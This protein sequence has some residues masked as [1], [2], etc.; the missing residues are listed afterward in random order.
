M[1][2]FEKSHN[3]QKSSVSF[4]FVLLDVI[5]VI[6]SHSVC[7]CSLYFYLVTDAP[8]RSLRIYTTKA[9]TSICQ[10]NLLISYF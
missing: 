9:L 3:Y 1:W 6:I 7:Q 4:D 5:L 8:E 10:T 2:N